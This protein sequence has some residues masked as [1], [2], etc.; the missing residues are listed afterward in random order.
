MLA[1]AVRESLEF[2]E[3]FMS[4]SVSQRPAQPLSE[5]LHRRVSR[6]ADVIGSREIQERFYELGCVPGTA[7]QVVQ[8]MAMG[9]PVILAVRGCRIAVRRS[10]LSNVMVH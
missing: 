1:V 3:T 2:E 7:I 6:I 4:Q 9:G 10:D 8:E 5:V